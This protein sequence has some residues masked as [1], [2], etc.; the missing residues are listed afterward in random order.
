MTKDQFSRYKVYPNGQ[1]YDLDR[2]DF[3]KQFKSNKYLQC[4]LV[5]NNGNAIVMGVHTVVAMFLLPDWFEGC[6]VHHKDGDTKHNEVTN[7]QCMSREEHSRHHA[8]CTRLAEYIKSNG[9]HNKGKKMSAEF[10]EK[11]RISA[12]KRH[13]LSNQKP[14]KNGMIKPF[15]I[16]K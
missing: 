4:R 9:P 14:D 2:K 15:I 1:I 5:D 12:K 13:F 10:C 7:L 16:I 6:I 11:C 3:L 8:D